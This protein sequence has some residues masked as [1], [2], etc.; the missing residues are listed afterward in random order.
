MGITVVTAIASNATKA[1]SANMP[2]VVAAYAGPS[3][4][5]PASDSGRGGVAVGALMSTDSRTSS[6]LEVN[7]LVAYAA[8]RAYGWVCWRRLVSPGLAR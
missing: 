2:I 5:V 3:R 4:R 7:G 8:T 1:I 6:E